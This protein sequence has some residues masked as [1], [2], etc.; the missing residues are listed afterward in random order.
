MAGQ[1]RARPRR[2][3]VRFAPVGVGMPARNGRDGLACGSFAFVALAEPCLTDV[4]TAAPVLRQ[5]A[6]GVVA[7]LDAS[8]LFTADI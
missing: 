7:F 8:A 4:F 6:T 2:I 3:A 5:R 1:S